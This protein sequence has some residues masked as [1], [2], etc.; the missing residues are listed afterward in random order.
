MW[1]GER[2]QDGWQD[3]NPDGNG[4]AS[5]AAG[6]YM[7]DQIQ[8][9]SEEDLITGE[10]EMDEQGAAMSFKAPPVPGGS[11]EGGSKKKLPARRSHARQGSRGGSKK[12]AAGSRAKS[13]GPATTH[14]Q[15]RH[16][17]GAKSASISPSFEHGTVVTV[18][19][20]PQISG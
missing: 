1:R 2:W 15:F 12:N 8:E 17:V 20:A 10:G 6:M 16:T 18:V 19:T 3:G 9:D 11:T 4:A 5:E 13:K 7:T 14:A